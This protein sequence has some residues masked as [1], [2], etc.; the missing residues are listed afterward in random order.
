VWLAAVTVTAACCIGSVICFLE[1]IL[2]CLGEK[3][4]GQVPQ[5]HLRFACH[6]MNDSHIVDTSYF[7]SWRNS[8]RE[9]QGQIN[10]KRI[11][12]FFFLYIYKN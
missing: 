2:H 3:F 6:K 8:E 1:R 7:E 10:F 4:Q 5:E 12:I 11:S 9:K